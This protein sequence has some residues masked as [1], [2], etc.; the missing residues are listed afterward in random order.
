MPRPSAVGGRA[1]RLGD[2]H[3]AHHEGGDV[4][5]HALL[6]GTVRL[7]RLGLR[8]VLLWSGGRMM[9]RFPLAGM[10]MLRVFVAALGAVPAVMGVLVSV[11]FRWVGRLGAWAVGAFVSC[12]GI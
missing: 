12:V 8:L 10:L 1:L 3:R 9:M 7:L 11:M 4:V 6:A 5:A 2:P